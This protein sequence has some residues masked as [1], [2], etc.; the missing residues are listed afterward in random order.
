ME[1]Y[2]TNTASSQC[3]L[4]NAQK[5]SSNTT[6]PRKPFQSNYTNMDKS[7]QQQ[8]LHAMADVHHAR[9]TKISA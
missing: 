2:H 8:T 3:I 1:H 4:H 5:D 6:P 9:D 7:N